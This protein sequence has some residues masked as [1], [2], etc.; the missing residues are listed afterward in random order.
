MTKLANFFYNLP[1]ASKYMHHQISKQAID[2]KILEQDLDTA[3]TTIWRGTKIQKNNMKRKIAAAKRANGM[4]KQHEHKNFYGFLMD[5]G[6]KAK[7][8]KLKIDVILTV[9]LKL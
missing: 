1:L 7:L 4:G 9:Y 5:C 8:M 6:I 2:S 3:N